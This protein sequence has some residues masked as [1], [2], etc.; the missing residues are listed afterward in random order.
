MKRTAIAVVMLGS[1]LV[2]PGVAASPASAACE[3]PAKR[4]VY[5]ITNKS[6]HY[7]PTNIRSDWVILRSGGSITYAKTKAMTVSAS[8]TATVTAEAGAIFASASV[9]LGVTV[10]ASMSSTQAWSYSANVPAG[11]KYKYRLHAYHYTADFTVMKRTFSPSRCNY[12]NAWS[13]SQLVHH[14]PAK[15]SRNVWRLDRAAA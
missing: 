9:S 4:V 14:A 5:S 10:G 15:A 7:H 2:V 6:F 12:V 11:S 8:T 13:R 1:A 3:P